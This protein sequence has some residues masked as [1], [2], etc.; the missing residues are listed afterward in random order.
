VNN[1]QKNARFVAP[2]GLRKRDSQEGHSVIF[3]MNVSIH[4]AVSGNHQ[5]YVHLSGMT[6]FSTA[7][8]S[9]N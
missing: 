9:S 2:E 3:A 4:L 1:A 5:G 8:Q 7:I 6:L